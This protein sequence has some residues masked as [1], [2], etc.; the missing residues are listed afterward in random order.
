ALSYNC[1]RCTALKIF[2]VERR[3]AD[4][5]ADALTTAVG[6]LPAGMPWE[7]GVKLTPLPEDG[8]GAWLSSLVEDAVAKGARVLNPSGGERAGTY[9]HPAV[10][11]PVSPA[12]KIHDEEQFGPIV[13]IMPFDR[14]EEVVD[15]ITRS[16]YGQ[17]ASIFGRDGARVAA[18][19]DALA[20][21]VSRINLNSQC[22]RGPDA[23]PFTG[24]KASAEG[25][26][27]V[28]DALR[29]FSI[30]AMVAAKDDP[31]N[32]ALLSDILRERRSSFL[33]TDF[34]F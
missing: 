4:A 8:K 13:P 26:L 18:L 31:D 22:Q 3:I 12:M 16:P 21:Q 30:R 25:T 24:R 27:S 15:L 10:L 34:L 11:Y 20:A 6:R 1:Q 28:G 7:Q 9:F 33:S 29:V 23:F 2:Y 17:Q 32:R 5:F 14:D 19:V